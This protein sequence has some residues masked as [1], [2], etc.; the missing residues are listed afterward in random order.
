MPTHT[1]FSGVMTKRPLLPSCARPRTPNPLES[2]IEP[3]NLE[4]HVPVRQ[5][6]DNE[7]AAVSEVLV[8]IQRLGVDHAHHDC[9][10]RAESDLG[11]RAQPAP[12][13]P[14]PR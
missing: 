1:F 5:R 11:L 3:Y 4:T 10:L 2:R 12:H 7:A 8:A 14:T 9:L 13:T 6:R